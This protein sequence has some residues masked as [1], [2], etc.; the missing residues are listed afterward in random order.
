MVKFLRPETLYSNKFEGYRNE[1][2]D[3]RVQANLVMEHSNMSASEMRDQMLRG[4]S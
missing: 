1:K 3:S 2:I 4:E